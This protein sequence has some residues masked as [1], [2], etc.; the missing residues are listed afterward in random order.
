MMR[1]TIEVGEHPMATGL[2][3]AFEIAWEDEWSRVNIRS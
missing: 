2:K 3:L 1:R